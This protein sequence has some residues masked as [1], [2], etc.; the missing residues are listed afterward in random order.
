[1]IWLRTTVY[2]VI[3]STVGV[4]LFLSI[5]V[6]VVFR[7]RT[8][9]EVA[10]RALNALRRQRQQNEPSHNPV[11]RDIFLPPAYG[12]IIVNIN[13]GVQ[14]VPATELTSLMEVPPPYTERPSLSHADSPPPPYA[15]FDRVQRTVDTTDSGEGNLQEE[16]ELSARTGETNTVEGGTP[17]I[18]GTALETPA[19]GQA[20]TNE[21]QGEEQESTEQPMSGIIEVRDGQIVCRPESGRQVVDSV[22]RTLSGQLVVRDGQISLSDGTVV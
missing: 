16:N 8:R 18:D 15:T 17:T 22:H 5:M 3:G 1:M 20:I 12:N 2:A 7:V 13:N 4:V 11:E 10:Q 9:R 6:I 21:N 19:I 14:F